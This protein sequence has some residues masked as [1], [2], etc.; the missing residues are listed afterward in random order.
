MP[1]PPDVVDF[2]VE[3]FR[4]LFFLGHF[5]QLIFSRL[6]RKLKVGGERKCERVRE[7]ARKEEEEKCE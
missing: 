2:G 7:S 4:C 3:R 1:C 5:S 6:E